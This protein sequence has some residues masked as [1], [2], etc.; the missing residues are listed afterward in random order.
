MGKVLPNLPDNECFYCRTDLGWA[1]GDAV[2][3]DRCWMF[4][5]EQGSARVRVDKDDCDI[6]CMHF[7]FLRPDLSLKV[8][9]ASED[10]SVSM[11][12]F[13][14]SMLHESLQKK[15]PDFMFM[16]ITKVVWRL[17]R[18]G[19]RM[20]EHFR[21][22][23]RFAVADYDGGYNSHELVRAL[24]T[25]F[26]YGVHKF[27]KGQWQERVPAD[28][29]RSRELFRKFVG[30]LE[31]NYTRQHDVQFYAD[32]LCI[33]AKYLTRI[34]KSTV[35]RTPKQVIDSRI[36]YEAIRLLE[37]DEASIQDISVRL[38]FPDQ[39]YFGRFFKRLKQVSPQ[40]YR[41]YPVP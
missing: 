11:M 4:V 29:S 12:C 5:V 23:F 38:G 19:R 33:S 41:M 35:G 20:L 28:S 37:R 2:W 3:A 27:C 34:S 9:H 24:L 31:K 17:D 22:L 40:Q 39:S 21:E 7:L 26:V 6:G 14:I 8:Q 32:S 15:G 13:P 30:L 18:Q 36:L 10:F 1:R 16:F 25:G